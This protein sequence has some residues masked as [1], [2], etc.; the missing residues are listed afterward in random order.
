MTRTE[1]L[2][3]LRGR[4][5]LA[6]EAAL[7]DGT[8]AEINT[9]NR[10]IMLRL[11]DAAAEGALQEA[12]YAVEADDAAVDLASAAASAGTSGAADQGSATV[13]LASAAE[14]EQTLADYLAKYMADRPAWHKWI[15]LACLF[16]AFAVGEPMHPQ[17]TAHWTE[18]DGSYYC[19]ARE[20]QPGSVC[21]WCVCK[22]A[23]AQDAQ[24]PCCAKGDQH[25]KTDS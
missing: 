11:L 23:A 4:I 9:Y 1:F 5:S 3:G 22:P 15:I 24:P 20:D 2:Q 18:K 7:R 14:L 16:S 25:G 21:L 12:G 19:A 6:E 8:L 13:D 17:E 10:K